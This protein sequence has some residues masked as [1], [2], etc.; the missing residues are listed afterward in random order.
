MRKERQVDS[1]ARAPRVRAEQLFGHPLP[2][3]TAYVY[4][5]LPAELSTKQRTPNKK[6]IWS[7]ALEGQCCC[8]VTFTGTDTDSDTG[9][10]PICHCVALP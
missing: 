7:V 8:A 5:T 6:N 3:F 9:H 1:E 4:K 2:D 10:I